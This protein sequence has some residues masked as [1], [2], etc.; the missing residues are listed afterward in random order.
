MLGILALLL[1]AFHIW[2]VYH[3]KTLLEDTVSK[4]TNGKIKLKIAKLRY[5]YFS[6][7]MILSEAVFVTTDTLTAN[8]AYR[9]RIP[10]LRLKLKA[11]LPLLLDKKLLIDSLS[12]LSPDIEVTTLRYG[13]DT[14]QYKKGDISIPYE[15]GRVY[16]SIRD[17]LQV[18]KVNRFQ[19][20]NGTFLLVNR[21]SPTDLPL[22]I[23]N[24]DFHIDNLQVDSIAPGQKEKLLFSDNI[25]LK[26]TDQHIIFPDGRHSLSYRKFRINLKNQLVEFDSCTIASNRK[27]SS[28][29][30]FR[31]FFDSLLLTH[32]DFDTL[33]RTELIKADSVYCINPAFSLYV[34]LG[35]KKSKKSKPPRLED[36]IEQLTGDLELGYLGVKNGDFNIRTVRDDKPSSFVSKQNNFDMEG[37]AVDQSGVKPIRVKSFAMAIRNYDNFIRDSSYRIKFDSIVF[38][39]DRITL[40]N[41]LF[42]KLDAGK[43]INTF[44]VPRFSLGGLSWN[45]LVFDKRIRANVV[46]MYEPHISYTATSKRSREKQTIFQSLGAL[47]EYMDLE[48]LEIEHGNLDLHLR[49]NL[50][51]KLNDASL[52]VQS[53]ALLISQKIAGIRN[54]LN[55]LDFSS[56]QILAGDLRISMT[57]IQ[58]EGHSGAVKAGLVTVHNNRKNLQVILNN[59]S[60]AQLKLDEY[61]GNIKAAGINWQKGTIH[62]ETETQ[63]AGNIPLIHLEKIKGTNTSV[64]VHTPSQLMKAEIA[65]LSADTFVLEKGKAP[66]IRQLVTSGKS[67]FYQRSPLMVSTSDFLLDDKHHSRLENVRYLSSDKQHTD[68]AFIPSL[69]FIPDIASLLNGVLILNQVQMEQPVIYS[70]KSAPLNNT[71]RT[72]PPFSRIS[73]GDLEIT[74]PQVAIARETGR[75]HFSLQWEGNTNAANHISIKGLTY[76]T[77]DEPSLQIGNLDFHF[78]SLRL[79]TTKGRTYTTGEGTMEGKASQIHFIQKQDDNPEWNIVF[80]ELTARKLE[81]D[82]LGKNGGHFQLTQSSIEHLTLND[83]NFTRLQQLVNTNK[84][85]SLLDFTGRFSNNMIKLQWYNAAYTGN[86]GRFSMDSFAYEPALPR[87]SFMATK[88]FQS[89]YIKA[90]FGKFTAGP[91]FTDEWFTDSVLHIRHTSIDR[92]YLQDYKDRTMPF[93]HGLIKPLPV[94][95]LK[96]IPIQLHADTVL[97]TNGSVDYTEV[98]EKSKKAVTIPI[99]RMTLALYNIKNTRPQPTDSLR[100]HANG[101]LLDTVWVRLRVKESYTDSLGGFLMTVRLKPGDLRVLNPVLIPMASVKLLS[102]ELD[103][104]NM[105]AVGREYLALGEMNMYYDNLRIQLLKN[106][107]DSGKTFFTRL[108]NFIANTFIIR[109]NNHSRTGNVFF[110]RQRDRSAIN[111]LIKIAISGMASSVG[112]KNN[113]KMMRRYERELERR[114]LPPIDFE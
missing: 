18:L 30:S 34:N 64:F 38:R 35:S 49:N 73:I 5:N 65:V 20:T 98:Q 9:F 58:Y 104:L 108:A 43:I 22:R 1:L 41:F 4:Q 54:S 33:Y 2:F 56:G 91:L 101:Y 80:D 84:H 66:V 55:R 74:S 113:R 92:V 62:L 40:S 27:D 99:R 110:I 89:D 69:R 6:Q 106:G 90:G 51:V 25:V 70:Q 28:G 32:I 17:G 29:S 15:M 60:V 8:S 88:S 97:L 19:I 37:L 36:I 71:G 24:I 46:T 53:N 82:S 31:V 111:Y 42:H 86:S 7:K 63:T 3:A 14:S 109:K 81:L 67:L 94:S 79:H 72:S 13:T 59:T 21:A 76:H 11:L 47:N 75:G 83:N 44:S 57:G 87:D 77:T 96:K 78:Q 100:I 61:S 26:S 105:R 16:K 112:A 12:L 48:L 10:E 39:D 95:L 45:D 50:Q 68:S 85:I 114:H 93:N 102:G 107:T 23:G 52:S 103:T